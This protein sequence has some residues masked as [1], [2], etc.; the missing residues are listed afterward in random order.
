[1]QSSG[2]DV[3][4]EATDKH[5]GVGIVIASFFVIVVE[6]RSLMVAEVSP[7]SLACREESLIAIVPMSS[8]RTLA[9]L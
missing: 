6:V 1:M 8:I 7:N 2:D 5:R 4:M 3:P 9:P